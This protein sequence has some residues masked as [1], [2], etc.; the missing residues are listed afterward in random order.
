MT[1]PEYFTKCT[2]RNK[3]FGVDFVTSL[4]MNTKWLHQPL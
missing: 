2:R 4:G 3:E 1:K